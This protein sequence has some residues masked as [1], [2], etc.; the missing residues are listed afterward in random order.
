[1]RLVREESPLE[2]AVDLGLPAVAFGPGPGQHAADLARQANPKECSAPR[3]AQQAA[4]V[5]LVALFVQRER[6]ARVLEPQ[7]AAQKECFARRVERQVVRVPMEAEFAR[8][9]GPGSATVTEIG[10]QA[11]RP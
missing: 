8:S 1:M 3:M 9:R 4:Q 6:Q 5:P 10:R 7:A 2:I 11:A